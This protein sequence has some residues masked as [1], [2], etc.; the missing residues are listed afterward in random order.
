MGGSGV[1]TSPSSFLSRVASKEWN[2]RALWKRLVGGSQGLRACLYGLCHWKIGWCHPWCETDLHQPR[3]WPSSLRDPAKE[4]GG[5]LLGKQASTL[6]WRWVALCPALPVMRGG[7]YQTT[8]GAGKEGDL[9]LL[10][11]L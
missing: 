6:A 2:T 1:H 5:R 9:R 4:A 8:W 11:A 3:I 10:L 7:E